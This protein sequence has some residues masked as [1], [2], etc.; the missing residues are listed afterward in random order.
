MTCRGQQRAWMDRMCAYSGQTI[1]TDAQLLETAAA[2]RHI[3]REQNELVVLLTDA[4]S[5]PA[6]AVH[7]GG[8]RELLHAAFKRQ[9]GQKRPKSP[10]LRLAGAGSNEEVEDVLQEQHPVAPTFAARMMVS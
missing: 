4:S 5:Q 1:K 10:L 7:G 2:L 8:F 3:V 6:R 9:A